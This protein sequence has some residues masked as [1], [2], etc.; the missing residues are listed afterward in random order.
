MFVGSRGYS[1]WTSYRKTT[2]VQIEL[3]KPET[4]LYGSEHNES[5]GMI[6]TDYQLFLIFLVLHR[7]DMIALIWWYKQPQR[8][9]CDRCHNCIRNKY[10]YLKNFFYSHPGRG[11]GFESHPSSV[12]VDFVLEDLGKH[13]VYS[14]NYKSM[15]G[16]KIKITLFIRDANYYIYKIERN[17]IP[18]NTYRNKW[19][20]VLIN[21][22]TVQSV[23][24][25]WF[26]MTAK[27]RKPLISY[28]VGNLSTQYTQVHVQVMCAVVPPN[29]TDAVEWLQMV[30]QLAWK[31]YP[32]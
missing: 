29:T 28:V 2:N 19:K 22:P 10:S 24:P 15:Y 27:L 30:A 7:S 23:I 11:R 6:W 31:L 5:L 26:W 17:R 16:L 9:A 21:L 1:S 20:H 12:P 18:R 14:A 8:S 32:Q 3:N 13:W 4:K 25:L